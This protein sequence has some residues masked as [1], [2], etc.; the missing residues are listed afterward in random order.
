M[1][2]ELFLM[3]IFDRAATFF[4]RNESVDDLIKDLG[5]TRKRVEAMK[6]L[7][8]MG[9]RVISNLVAVLDDVDRQA[10]AAA[11]LG[12]SGEQAIT[13]LVESLDDSSRGTYAAL[14]LQNIGKPKI[15]IPHLLEA[16]GD[17]TRQKSAS[18]VLGSY[19]IPTLEP[20]IPSLI[21]ALGD[22]SK[23][24]YA[25]VIFGKLGPAAI[26]PLLKALSEE[27]KRR[28]ALIALNRIDP[29]KYP[30][31]WV[32]EMDNQKPDNE[33]PITPIQK[34]E[35]DQLK[36][37][38]MPVEKMEDSKLTIKQDTNTIFK[39]TNIS[40]KTQKPT[41]SQQKI[42]TQEILSNLKKRLAEGNLSES[43]YSELKKEYEDK[44][45]NIDAEMQKNSARL[46]EKIEIQRQVDQLRKRFVA[47]EI[48]EEI[49]KEL[50]VEYQEKLKSLSS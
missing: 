13:P 42:E 16:L 17:K 31:Q 34:P 7:S 8:K 15:I 20:Y 24:A 30:D 27:N 38:N 45:S 23:Q 18:V 3:S 5:D 39:K 10:Y 26:S 35:S 36:E 6:K 2:T 28:F 47:G 49:F 33:K 9:S 29:K 25:T 46:E 44:I 1:R 48:S 32:K 50:R 19:D 41:P 12:D 11:L 37:K 40:E 4:G 21:E 22:R 14:A 43:T